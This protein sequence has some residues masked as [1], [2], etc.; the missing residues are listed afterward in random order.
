MTQKHI[1]IVGAGAIGAFYG[2]LLA[3]AGAYVSVVCRSDYQQVNQYGYQIQSE[4]LGDWVFKPVETLKQAADSTQPI[5]YLILC[6]KVTPDI[7]RVGLIRKAVK[8]ETCLVMI[9][10]GINIEQPLQA[11]FPNNEIISGL[12]FVCCHKIAPGVINHLAYGKLTLGSLNSPASQTDKA[13]YLSQLIRQAGI[14]SEVSDNI[15]TSRWLKCLWNA[16]FNPLSVLSDGLT[17]QQMIK[18]QTPFIRTIMQEVSHIAA[19]CGHPLPAD[20][21]ET[22]IANTLTMPAYKTSMLLDYEN[23]RPMEIEAILGNTI[24]AAQ[25]QVACPTLDALYALIKL[26]ILKHD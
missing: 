17:T 18:T 19:A 1:L 11:A 2:G 15:T 10:N 13:A 16:A 22:N 4:V 14:K 3:K 5:D 26:K 6:T 9:Q 24:K 8:P 23:H 21:I 12:A 7:D 25:Q 20:S